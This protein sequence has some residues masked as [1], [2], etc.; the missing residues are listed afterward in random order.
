MA[1]DLQ[2][3]NIPN[4]Q[5]QHKT[6]RSNDYRFVNFDKFQV[7]NELEE[8]DNRPVIN[9]TYFK[10]DKTFNLRH[11]Q[12][13]KK[14]LKSHFIKSA[15]WNPKTHMVLTSKS[16]EM[17]TNIYTNTRSFAVRNQRQDCKFKMRKASK[18]TADMPQPGYYDTQEAYDKTFGHPVTNAVNMDQDLD[19]KDIFSGNADPDAWNQLDKTR[20]KN[21]WVQH[22]I[23]QIRV[24]YQN[25]MSRQAQTV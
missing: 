5:K 4:Q 1:K 20:V 19:R 6:M 14:S 12:K 15:Y 24:E 11:G 2:S 16:N 17:R 9:P 23:P 21:L 13:P 18:N 22:E 10:T 7:K 8:I 25:M 3:S